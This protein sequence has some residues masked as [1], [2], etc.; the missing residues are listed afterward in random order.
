MLSCHMD[1]D[2]SVL[3]IQKLT[4][5]QG[6]EWHKAPERDSPQEEPWWQA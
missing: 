4:Q 2:F 3:T 1:E 5:T 6:E